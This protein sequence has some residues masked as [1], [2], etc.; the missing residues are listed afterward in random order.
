TVRMFDGLDEDPAA[1]LQF[2]PT[3]SGIEIDAAGRGIIWVDG[4]TL[5][6]LPAGT[7]AARPLRTDV[8]SSW[9]VGSP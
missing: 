9:F 4:E 2:P 5:Y 6:S 3:V 7:F 8:R 1:R